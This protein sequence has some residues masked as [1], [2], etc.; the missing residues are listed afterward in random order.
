MAMATTLKKC[1]KLH[2]LFLTEVGR[3]SR[4]ESEGFQV[5]SSLANVSQRVPTLLQTSTANVN[6][7]IDDDVDGNL[8]VMG[9]LGFSRNTQALL[10]Q[11]HFLA[12]EKSRGFLTDILRDY[13]ELLRH[14]RS[15]TSEC[16]TLVDDALIEG[17][18]AATVADE[19]ATVTFPLQLQEWMG[20]VLTMFEHEV[21]RKTR[22][23]ADLE[24]NDTGRLSVV[25]K[26]WSAKGAVGNID[27]DYVQTGL[28]LP[29]AKSSA[30][31]QSAES[32][33]SKNKNKK[34]KKNKANNK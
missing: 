11:K 13:Q 6:G 4:L 5:L 8:G 16:A 17:E 21:L 23:V 25:A 32:D 24:Y 33:A 9:V 12:L 2:K 27:H 1:L 3:S 26:Q 18:S 19:M 22:L 30:A 14:L 31:S 34:K 20:I 28:P 7:S 29:Q 15:F 10:L